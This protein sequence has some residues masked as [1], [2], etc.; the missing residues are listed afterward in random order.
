M[1]RVSSHA[2][3]KG[4]RENI[5]V[6]DRRHPA[7]RDAGEENEPSRRRPE[8]KKPLPDLTEEAWE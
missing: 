2:R 6:L 1:V 3:E 5:H 7:L 8:R 4:M